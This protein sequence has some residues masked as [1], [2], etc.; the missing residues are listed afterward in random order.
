MRLALRMLAILLVSASAAA[1]QSIQQDLFRTPL[2]PKISASLADRI[3]ASPPDAKHKV[4]VFFTD[5][6]LHSRGQLIEALSAPER[7]LTARAIARRRK[8]REAASLCEFPDL[9][10]YEP[11]VQAI[12]ATGARLRTR[13][14]WLNAVSVHATPRQ[15]MDIAS[16]PFVAH[17]RPVLGARRPQ[18]EED[19]LSTETVAPQ[20]TVPRYRLDYG[21]SKEQ[22]EQIQVPLLHELG[23]TGRGVLVAMF[24]TGFFKRHEAFSRLRIVAE[25]DFVMGDGDTERDLDDP[26]DYSDAHG[27]YTWST[28]AGFW[29]G[30]L[31]GPAYGADFLLAK[32]E[33]ER[34]ETPVEEDYWAAAAEWADSLGADVISSS[35]GYFDWYRFEDMDGNTAVC[36]IAA[37]WAARQGMAVVVAAGNWNSTAW[38]HISAPADGDSVIA[39]GAVD[40]NGTV[41]SWSSRGPTYDGRIKPEVCARGVST[42]CASRRSASAYGSASGTSLSTPLVGGVCALLLE[43]HPEWTGWEV[44]QALLETATQAH[45]PD[46][47]YGWGIVQAFAA[48]GIRAAVPICTSFDLIEPAASA[49][50]VLDPGE[51]VGFRLTIRNGGN[52]PL[53]G[54][55]RFHLADSSVIPLDTLFTLQPILPAQ[56]SEIRCER[57]LRVSPT[58]GKATSALVRFAIGTREG[59]VFWRD[60][61]CRLAGA[62][63]LFGMVK[64]LGTSGPVPGASVSIRGHGAPLDSAFHLRATSQG[65]FRYLLPAG[66]YVVQATE[67]GYFPSLAA[68]FSMPQWEGGIIYLSLSRPSLRWRLQPWAEGPGGWLSGGVDVENAGDGTL[69]VTV[70]PATAGVQEPSLPVEPLQVEL[71]R[72]PQEYTLADV[73][74][75][76]ATFEE[77]SVR[78]S[79]L[80]YGAPAADRTWRWFL[81]FDLDN[82]ENTGERV[83]G[84]GADGRIVATAEGATVETYV[85]GQWLPRMTIREV[86]LVQSSFTVTIPQS[87]LSGLTG[88]TLVPM[89]LEVQGRGMGPYQVYDRVPD[90]G[91]WR[92]FTLARAPRGLRLSPPSCSVESRQ[93]SGFRIELQ[94]AAWQTSPLRIVLVSWDPL[95]PVQ[96]VS[97]SVSSC[98]P[99]ENLPE[100]WELT[101]PFPNPFASRTRIR[102]RGPAG[103]DFLLQIYDLR[104]REVYRATKVVPP[105]GEATID[106]EGRS[107]TGEWLPNGLY[108]ARLSVA[109]QL[110]AFRK[111]MLLR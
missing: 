28:L 104:G 56:E 42:R 41:A 61:T 80:H 97:L 53:G 110:R 96:E 91:P 22:L 21:P 99:V 40:A 29:E 27:T 48:S 101:E 67:E 11:Y 13:S 111:V 16:L 31:I 33:D 26:N 82:D 54:S 66:R 57:V 3:Q 38:G 30:E 49:N 73:Q 46:N 74:S 64:E 1:S 83:G 55:L 17:L 63:E 4:W 18:V 72:D 109:T 6:G 98:G 84:L 45:R 19:H 23:Y 12:L 25:R 44:R 86:Q 50:G 7:Y 69:F 5:K 35:L 2:A 78:F 65:H 59:F 34:S 37:D 51:E 92:A 89:Y 108:V 60:V 70:L 47:A 106:W 32:T 15:L 81:H 103:G 105:H 62:Y 36:T 100:K 90:P 95:Q 58:P 93:G 10:V 94:R 77:S 107:V 68:Q 75:I 20:I 24:D 14:R 52:E 88:E 9:P 8:V 79:V 39:V 71:W 76:F 102:V 87:V 85:G 43:A